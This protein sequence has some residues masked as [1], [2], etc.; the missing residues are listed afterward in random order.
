MSKTRI[1]PPTWIPVGELAEAF[2][3]KSNVLPPTTDLKGMDLRLY[4]EN[5]WIIEHRFA[6]VNRLLWRET[7]S[8][9]RRRWTE[10][11][12]LATKVR[13]GIYFID[14]LRH[15]ERATTVS[16]ALDLK[17]GIFT[18]VIGQLPTRT[19]TK[20]GLLDRV[21]EGKELTGV[22]ATFLSGSVNEVFDKSKAVRHPRTDELLGKRIE[23]TYSPTERYEHVY[24]NR[25]FYTWHCLAGAERKEG[26]GLADTDR[27]HYYK[28]GER[29]YLFSWQEKIIPTHGVV[30]IDLD[31][32]RTTGKIFGYAG[33]NLGKLTN[34]PVGAKARLLAQIPRED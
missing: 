2:E 30:I 10:E 20:E 34:F 32:M 15:L 22:K 18:A 19:E 12:Y 28:L 7:S 21:V 27:C 16:L 33:N 29:L 9:G 3:R 24:L 13:E 6:T 26:I 11:N 14:F 5:G 23:Y 1:E 4:F 8:A 17:A 25:G 31:E